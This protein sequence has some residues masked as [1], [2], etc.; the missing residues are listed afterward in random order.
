[1]AAGSGTLG[2]AGLPGSCRCSRTPA[3]GQGKCAVFGSP[4]SVRTRSS[5]SERQTR[6]DQV[7]PPRMSAVAL[8]LAPFAAIVWLSV[9]LVYAVVM[10]AFVVTVFPVRWALAYWRAP[11]AD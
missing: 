4:T 6:T 7:S 8:W 11:H 3:F 10:A 9:V 5:S 1:V 2:L